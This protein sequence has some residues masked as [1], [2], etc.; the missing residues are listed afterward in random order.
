MLRVLVWE[1][2][3]PRPRSEGIT[4]IKDISPA[5]ALAFGDSETPIGMSDILG[6]DPERLYLGQVGET[7]HWGTITSAFVAE[8]SVTRGL[9]VN[10]SATE[11]LRLFG[12]HPRDIPAGGLRGPVVIA[13]LDVDGRL[14]HAHPSVV[15]GI[16]EGLDGVN[17]DVGF[18]DGLT[19]PAGVVLDTPQ[20]FGA[21]AVARRAGCDLLLPD[22]MASVLIG[23]VHHL[24]ANTTKTLRRT[25][26][27]VPFLRC[28][29]QLAVFVHEKPKAQP[30]DTWI[31]IPLAHYLLLPVPPEWDPNSPAFRLETRDHAAKMMITV[32]DLTR[33][34]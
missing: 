4:Q 27:G 7:D 16:L 24:L 30:L 28:H 25:I 34:I 3:A 33:G 21:N 8:D 1:P 32:G 10:E 22:W 15:A 31:D 9:P 5:M 26:T 6:G 13:G 12:L 18:P 17:P 29:A 14:T 23:D 19:I 20:L 11:V 2:G